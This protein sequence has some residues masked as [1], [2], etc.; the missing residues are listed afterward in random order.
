MPW[1]IMH[2]RP[3]DFFMLGSIGENEYGKTG[4][5]K[6]FYFFEA[7]LDHFEAQFFLG[8]QYY[9]ISQTLITRRAVYLRFN[10]VKRS[11]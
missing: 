10:I 8:L 1:A 7:L 9:I 2:G 11:L 4:H 5:S 6:I 3:E